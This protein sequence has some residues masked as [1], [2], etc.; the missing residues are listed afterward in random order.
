MTFNTNLGDV[1]SLT[2][3]IM[4]MTG[5]APNLVV[6]EDVQGLP[7]SFASLNQYNGLPLGSATLTDLSDLSMVVNGLEE[8][9]AYY[10]RVT[11]SNYIGSGDLTTCEMIPALHHAYSSVRT[12]RVRAAGRPMELTHG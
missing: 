9:V 4:S 7:P 6:S 8:G 2:S 10:F 12:R 1:P 3:D 5:T 11:A